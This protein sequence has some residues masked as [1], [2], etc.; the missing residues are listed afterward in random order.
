MFVLTYLQAYLLILSSAVCSLLMSPSKVFIIFVTMI[1]IASISFSLS[2][3]SPVITKF[4][5]YHCLVVMLCLQNCVYTISMPCNFCWKSGLMYRVIGN[6][7]SRLLLWGF[8]LI[9]IGLYLEFTIAV[10][11]RGFNFLYCSCFCLLYCLWVLLR[12]FFFFLTFFWVYLFMAVLGLRFFA[13]ASSS[14]GKWGPLFIT[15]HGP[16]TV[17]ASLVAEHRLQTYR[18]SK[19]WLMGLVAPW[20]VGSSQTRARTCVPCIGRQT[21]NHCATREAPRIFLQ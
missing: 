12:I 17:V 19:L 18:L 6:D 14:C 13:R 2:V 5:S 8:S 9:W 21:L 1:L 11:P 16:L 20:H 3:L 7:V 10:V 15:E 4:V